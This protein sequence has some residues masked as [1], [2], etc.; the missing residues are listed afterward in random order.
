MKQLRQAHFPQKSVHLQPQPQG[1]GYSCAWGLRGVNRCS[2]STATWPHVKAGCSLVWGYHTTE[3]GGLAA[4]LPQGLRGAMGTCPLSTTHSSSSSISTMAE[5]NS[6][7][8][9]RGRD[10][11]LV[12][13]LLGAQL[14]RPQAAP[15]GALVPVRAAADLSGEDCSCP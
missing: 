5:H 1:S 7:T 15:S 12:A 14:C 10:P 11:G 4:A 2:S 9:H 8:G 6:C 13:S 3:W